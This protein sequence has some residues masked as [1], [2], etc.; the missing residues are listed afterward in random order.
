MKRTLVIVIG[1]IIALLVMVLTLR[2]S[3]FQY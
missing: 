2:S 1:I 3:E